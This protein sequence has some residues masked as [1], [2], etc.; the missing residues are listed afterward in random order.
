MRKPAKEDKAHHRVPKL[1]LEEASCWRSWVRADWSE[2]LD[3]GRHYVMPRGLCKSN[4]MFEVEQFWGILQGSA[5]WIANEVMHICMLIRTVR[6]C[7]PQSLTDG[8]RACLQEPEL[9]PNKLLPFVLSFCFPLKK[10]NIG[11]KGVGE[12]KIIDW[13]GIRLRI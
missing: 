10:T 5:I 1:V 3:K 12:I 11:E 4:A 6:V 13:S 8:L 9:V 7:S 2:G